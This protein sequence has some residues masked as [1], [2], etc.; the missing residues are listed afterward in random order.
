MGDTK[1]FGIIKEPGKKARGFG[2]ENELRA[3]QKAVGGY[4]EAVPVTENVRLLCNEDGKCLGLP[5]NFFLDVEGM[6]VRFSAEAGPNTVDEVVG[7][8]I[9]LQLDWTTG[10][11]E[12]MDLDAQGELLNQ[13][14]ALRAR[15]AK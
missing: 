13:L 2:I 1:I 4:I 12:D 8:V 11:F 3:F 5:H 15:R 10:E 14:W 9:F 6:T 7:T